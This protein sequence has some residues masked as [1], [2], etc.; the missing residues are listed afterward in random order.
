MFSRWA[1][2][3]VLK[4]LLKKKLGQFIVG[5]LDLDQLEVQLGSGTIQLTDLALNVDYINHKLGSSPVILKEGSI[6]SLLAKIPWRVNNCQIEVNELELVFIPFVNKDLSLGDETSSSSS[7]T[8]GCKQHVSPESGSPEAVN[9]SSTGVSLD[10]HEGV[11]TIAKMVKWLLTSFHINVKKL[12]VAFEPYSD[13]EKISGSH[14]ALVLRIAELEYGTCV[15]EENNAKSSSPVD[16]LLGLSRLTNFITFQGAIIEFLHMDDVENKNSKTRTPVASGETLCELS[17]GNSFLDAT[18]PILT[19]EGG[20]FSGNLKLSL[21]W[22]NGSLDIHKVDADVS[23]DPI[24]LKLQPSTITWIVCLW[25]SLK[26]VDRDDLL[27]MHDSNMNS[28][29]YTSASQFHCSTQG[30]AMTGTDRVLTS[31]DYISAGFFAQNSQGSSNDALLRGSHVIP[32]WL[33]LSTSIN[34]KGRVEPEPDLSASIDQFFECFDGLRTS[35]SALGNSGLLNW[36]CS[37]FSAITA[38]SSLASGS[39]LLPSEQQPVETNLRAF[40]SGIS[41]E[42]SLVDKDNKYACS[43]MDK[44]LSNGRNAHYLRAKCQDLRLVFQICPRETKFEA[45]LQHIDLDDLFNNTDAV[46]GFGTL[47]CESTHKQSL[48][49]QTLQAEVQG[50]LPRFPF[51]QDFDLGEKRSDSLLNASTVSTSGSVINSNCEEALKEDFVKA[52]VLTTLGTT[53]CQLTLKIAQLD[54]TKTSSTSFSVK[55]PPFLFWVNLNLVNKLL[56]LLND[57]DNSIKLKVGKKDTG[58]GHFHNKLKSAPRGD[59]KGNTSLCLTSSSPGGSIRGNISLSFARIILCFPPENQGDVYCYS[60]WHQFIGIDI[61]Q[62][63]EKE[64]FPAVCSKDGRLQPRLADNFFSSIYLKAE[65]LTMYLI[66]GKGNDVHYKSALDRNTYFAEEILCVSTSTNCSSCI[67][68]L[69]KDSPVTG[70]WVA[71]RARGLATSQGS[72]KNRTRVTGRGSEFASVTT[73][74]DQ[75]DASSCTQEMVFSSAFLVH[76]SLPSASVKLNSSQYQLLLHLFEQTM[77]HLSHV[78]LNGSSI[79]SIGKEVTVTSQSSV[80]V[81]CDSVDVISNLRKLDDVKQSLQSELPGSWN[82]LRVQIQKFELL[83]VSNIGGISGSNFFWIGHGKGELRGSIDECPDQEFLLISCADSTMRRGNGEGA[84]A[85]SS[86]SAG[87]TIVCL[88]DPQTLESFTTVTIRGGTIIA[89]GG[90]LDWLNAVCNL[91]SLPS[92]DSDPK[93]SLEDSRG[94]RASFVLNLVDIALSYEPRTSNCVI[95]DNVSESGFSSSGNVSEEFG[96]QVACLLAAASLNLSNQTV[97]KSAESVYKIRLQD[98]GLLICASSRPES[99]SFYDIEH[100]HKAGYVKVAGEA[101]VEAILRTN[102]DN[103]LLWELECCDSQINVDTCHDTITGLVRLS[104]QLQQLFAPDLQESL[105]HLQ[106]RWHAFQQVNCSNDFIKRGDTL[107]MDSASSS[108]CVKSSGQDANG[109]SRPGVVGL[110]D[111]IC[112]DAFKFNGN[113]TSPSEPCQSQSSILLERGLLGEAYCSNVTN[114]EYFSHNVN[115]NLS[116]SQ[117]GFGNF[118]IPTPQKDGSHEVIEGYCKSGHCPPATSARNRPRSNAKGKSGNQDQLG[119]ESGS[120]GWYKEN[121]PRIVDNH[122]PKLIKQVGGKEIPRKCELPSINCTSTNDNCKGGRVVLKNIDVRWRMYAGSDWHGSIKNSRMAGGG[123]RDTNVCLELTLSSVNL[124]YNMYPDGE[125]CVSEMSL[126]VQ[127]INLYDQSRNAPWKLILGYY[128]SKDHPRESS[129][130]AFKL[131]LKSVR[132]DPLAPLE[133]YRLRLAV[134]PMLLHL[135]QDHLDFLISFFGGKQSSVDQSTSDI[136]GSKMSQTESSNFG[137]I[138]IAEEALLPFFQQFDVWPIVVRVDYS[139]RRVDLAALRGG[140]Y[141]HLVNLVPWKG[142]ELQLKHVHAVGL[143]GWSS[144]CETIIGEWLEDISHNQIHKFLRGLPPVRSFFTVGSGAAKLV[145]LPVKS[146]KKDHRLLKGVQRGAIA[147][148]RSI[149][150]EAVGLGVHLAAGAHDILLQTEHIF[151]SI[152]PSVTSPTRS[153]KKTNVRSN[154]PKDA[155]QGIRQAVENL[156]DGIG[157]SASA[158]VGNPLKTY[159]RGGS[160]GSVLASAVCAAPSAAIAPASA[161]VRAVHSALLGVRNSLD[162]E[163]KKESMEKYFGPT[164]ALEHK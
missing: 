55:L 89:P 19:G 128:H 87:T 160:A 10:V 28:V 40:F 96:E 151:T 122:I 126:S 71:L 32:D 134:L 22:R 85:F 46:L 77:G 138:T 3:H 48:S 74:G 158:L 116:V 104:A 79:N 132:P 20:G 70:P 13:E 90:R 101:L 36:P 102:C 157:K 141:V 153:K 37:V 6:G 26:N 49:I 56:D 33:A 124:Q 66:A 29:Y 21:P 69:W 34:Q 107:D 117:A 119:F 114:P 5:D 75:E 121:S 52:K 61:M 91:F 54:S 118:C 131:N 123:G 78:A 62:A 108:Y 4:F 111:N 105:V 144:V 135:D 94:Y 95:P 83:S 155:Q 1:I 59:M 143:Y 27:H 115:L 8:E 98:L 81:E 68:V 63:L 154:Q 43:S 129:A 73:M 72:A 38:V 99:G 125:V 7:S 2:K 110:M 64:R 106:S 16:S 84:N 92:E 163:H 113:G 24:E 42:L 11:K 39:L 133:E 156:S 30:S 80:L 76:V 25:Q 100:L 53:P 12:I 45:M 136:Y 86:G 44:S 17:R 60:L 14:Q 50:A 88:C 41:I 130:N 148:L 35:H 142:V 162:P 67:G 139:P 58:F 47:G 150:L 51:S 161:A 137:G 103:G 97:V 127:D 120:S 145:S 57:I 9:R 149:S 18:T 109:S 140:N 65:N 15:S 93:G 164:Q 152:P 146:Y 159:Q 82:K 23:I 147:F 112:Q 31:S